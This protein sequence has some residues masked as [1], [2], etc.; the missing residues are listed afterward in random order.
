MEPWSLQE[1]QSAVYE[2][3]LDIPDLCK[4]FSVFGGVADICLY[5]DLDF[6]RCL[7]EFSGLMEGDSESVNAILWSV[8]CLWTMD[9]SSHRL[10]HLFPKSDRTYFVAQF[11]SDYVKQQFAE[12][13]YFAEPGC[14]RKLIQLLEKRVPDAASLRGWA[15]EVEAHAIL[16]KG[17]SFECCRVE[18]CTATNN[19]E[20]ELLPQQFTVLEAEKYWDYRSLDGAYVGCE[21]STIPSIDSYVFQGDTLYLFQCTISTK[22]PIKVDGIISLLGELRLSDRFIEGTLTVK[23]IFVTE[24]ETCSRQ[25]ILQVQPTVVKELTDIPCINDERAALLQEHGIHSVEQLFQAHKQGQVHKFSFI[26]KT[27]TKYFERYYMGGKSVLLAKIQ[28]IVQYRLTIK[29]KTDDLVV[30]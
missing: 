26:H 21:K 20:L 24:A 16:R 30:Y 22:H 19:F 5:P 15:F 23:I 25:D 28:E 6:E 11:A 1:M 8:G 12:N 2:L 14:R 4:R 17:G 9:V 18:N 10:F 27:V 29:L 7:A 3:N 13:V